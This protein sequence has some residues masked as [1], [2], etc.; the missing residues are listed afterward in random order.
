MNRTE[1]IAAI[2]SG[3]AKFSLSEVLVVF[4]KRLDDGRLFPRRVPAND[5]FITSSKEDFRISILV[6]S[7]DS[8]AGALAGGFLDRDDF[9]FVKG[10]IDLALFFRVPALRPCV[11]RE[12]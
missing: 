2:R 11:E 12:D 4:P 7:G 9:G 10:I 5:G 6:S 1:C 8:G 3:N